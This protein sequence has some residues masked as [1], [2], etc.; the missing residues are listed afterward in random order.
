MNVLIFSDTFLPAISGISTSIAM[1]IRE[2][3]AQ[4]HKVLLV[5]PKFEE[6]ENI[7]IAGVEI[8]RLPSIP[9]FVYPGLYL[10]TLNP[11][12]MRIVRE[13]QPDI[14]HLMTPASVGIEGLGLA[15]AMGWP[16][17]VTFHGYF[18]APEYIQVAKI[19]FGTHYV[20]RFLWSYARVF[21]NACNAVICPTN[22][23]KNDLKR[24]KF[25]KPLHVC[26]NGLEIDTS[27]KRKNDLKK[28]ISLHGLDPKKTAIYIG[29]TS[30]EK[31]IEELIDCFALV[32]QSVSDAKLLIIGAGPALQ[33]LQA[34]VEERKLSTHIIFTGE[35]QHQDILDLGILHAGCM[36][37][38]CSRSEVQ[39]MSMIEATAFGL[40]LVVYKARGAGDM[41]EGNGYAIK[42]GD[43]KAF[44]RAMVRIFSTQAL[45]K[46]F[47]KNAL[48]FAKR[49]NL[50]FCTKAMVKIYTEVV[51]S[52]TAK[53]S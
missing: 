53:S 3:A 37:V 45:Q 44:A 16:V 35:M 43:K 34:L 40:P 18:M 4:G 47:S 52:S 13:F 42:P 11:Q 26:S 33:E 10:G 7:H 24:H 51:E 9:A 21:F 38:S 50:D 31:S 1:L 41:V 22:Y 12:T 8:V 30:T 5:C 23:V 20:S 15:K 6:K 49:Y 36:F 32:L 28:F 29:R 46:K 14:V 19:N 17:V 27:M 39:P 48:Q 25:T 2:L